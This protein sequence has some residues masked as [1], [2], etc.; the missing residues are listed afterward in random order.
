MAAVAAPHVAVRVEDETS[1]GRSYS[2]AA[3]RKAVAGLG[4][5]RAA[6]T[7][8][9]LQVPPEGPALESMTMARVH[10]ARATREEV[11]A[12]F[13]NTWAL[14]ETL[15]SS[16]ANDSVFYMIP[17]PLRRPLVFYFGHPAVSPLPPPPPRP[18]GPPLPPGLCG[19]SVRHP[20][21]AA[22]HPGRRA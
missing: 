9:S 13:R 20:G 7:T 12:Y 4:A 15:F 3:Q 8:K 17:D 11:L 5:R 6:L 21:A 1:V 18:P 22:G 16:L 19:L 10:L 2:G 14:T